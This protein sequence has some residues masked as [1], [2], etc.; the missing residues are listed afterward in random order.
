MLPRQ[1]LKLKLKINEGFI[2]LLIFL[3][4]KKSS[5]SVILK[6]KIFFRRLF[7]YFTVTCIITTDVIFVLVAQV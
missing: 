1:F 4:V 2:M 7:S 6:R 3:N 5:I